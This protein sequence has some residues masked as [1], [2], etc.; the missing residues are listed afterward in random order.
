M[1]RAAR[2]SPDFS[3]SDP[4]AQSHQQRAQAVATAYVS[5]RSPRP[6]VCAWHEPSDTRRHGHAPTA[7]SDHAGVDACLA[8]RPELRRRHRRRGDRGLALAIGT[9]GLRDYLDD[10]LR[11]PRDLEAQSGAPVL[12]LI[13]AFRSSPPRD[14]GG[15][16]AVSASPNSVSWRPTA[17]CGRGWFTAALGTTDACSSRAQ[18][19]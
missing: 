19:P 16:L 5:Y 4:A 3:Y 14:P 13:P 1:S 8:G 2:P 9:A 12:A 18:R 6:P 10:R 17:P 7:V 15:Q 11:G